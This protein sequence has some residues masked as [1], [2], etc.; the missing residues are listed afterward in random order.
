MLP[1]ISNIQKSIDIKENNTDDKKLPF[2]KSLSNIMPSTQFK[3]T[4]NTRM[5][6]NY[7]SP[8]LRYINNS[9]KKDKSMINFSSFS[10]KDKVNNSSIIKNKRKK[11]KVIFKKYKKSQT[12]DKLY[13][14]LNEN[15]LHYSLSAEK[16]YIPKDDENV[17]E[18]NKQREQNMYYK[19]KKITKRNKT[20]I[21][22]GPIKYS[23][24]EEDNKDKM[25]FNNYLKLQSIADI[26]F[27]PRFGDTSY[28]L[29]NYI[30]KIDGIRK[31]IVNKLIKQ[32]NNV[33]DRF[34]YEN[35]EEDAKL[36]TRTQGLYIHKWKNIFLL[37][38][39][40]GLF[41]GNLKGKIS[42]KNYGEMVNGFQKI[43]NM[44]F[45]KGKVVLSKIAQI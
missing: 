24:I 34:N 39:Y 14:L 13:N 45:S 6:K 31:G 15:G 41:S 4:I 22:K 26:R 8:N 37:K 11:Y 5:K 16:Y 35:P 43:Y 29:V 27:R 9:L 42:H 28:D 20:L 10:S 18:L 40:Q 38:D 30:R 36:K 3:K 21:D 1:P 19:D 12:E 44:C 25:S 2:K 7:F 17:I 33:N 32:I 23:T